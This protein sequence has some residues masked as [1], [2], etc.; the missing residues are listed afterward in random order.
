MDAEGHSPSRVTQQRRDRSLAGLVARRTPDCVSLRSRSAAE[1]RRLR[2]ERR[3]HRRPRGSRRR[4]RSGRR[5]SRPTARTSPCRAIAIS[6][7]ID[8]ADKAVKRLT[9]E[10]QN[11]MSPSWSP[12]G[13]R[14]VFAST[15]NGR[16]EIFTMHADGSN[17][18]D[19]RVDAR[20]E[21]AWTRAGR[22]TARASRSCRCPTVEDEAAKSARSRT[23]STSSR[24]RAGE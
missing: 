7:V 8:L 14:I 12:D 24:W 22:P 6:V 16:L 15:R 4:A 18:D 5:N 11:G 9:F 21:R 10:P 2:D 13:S 20:R 17:Q 3:R 23:R 1:L 19:A